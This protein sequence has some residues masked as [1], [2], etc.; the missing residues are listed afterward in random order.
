MFETKSIELGYVQYGARFVD[1]SI[2]RF[3]MKPSFV[4]TL[5]ERVKRSNKFMNKHHKIT[6][7]KD[8]TITGIRRERVE[9]LSSLNWQLIY[10][11]CFYDITSGRFK[12]IKWRDDIEKLKFFATAYNHNFCASKENI[13]KWIN[14]RTFPYGTGYK[15]EQYSY[16]DISVYFY[17]NHFKNRRE[18]W[19]QIL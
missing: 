1:F 17:T 7:F 3:Q 10:L 4:E 2:G 15:G 14:A 18:P 16:S 13:E 9:R 12:D 6:V 5:E 19:K 8:T 11:E